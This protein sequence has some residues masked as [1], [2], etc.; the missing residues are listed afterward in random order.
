[1]EVIRRESWKIPSYQ[2]LDLHAG[3]KIKLSK[4]NKVR[5]KTKYYK[6]SR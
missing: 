1:M 3:Y 4:E 6:P 5:L 2:L